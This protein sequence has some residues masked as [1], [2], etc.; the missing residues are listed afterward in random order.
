MEEETV[1]ESAA[2]VRSGHYCLDMRFRVNAKIQRIQ[3]KNYGMQDL[4][5]WFSTGSFDLCPEIQAGAA[6]RDLAPTV[7]RIPIS[8]KN[9]EGFFPRP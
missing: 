6:A 7:V 1:R 9:L 4:S 8:L 5:A 2:E 3:L